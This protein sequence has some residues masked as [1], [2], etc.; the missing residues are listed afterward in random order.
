[1]NCAVAQR[2]E[3]SDSSVFLAR[4]SPQNLTT[5]SLTRRAAGCGLSGDWAVQAREF[6][7]SPIRSLRHTNVSRLFDC[8]SPRR[9]PAFVEIDSVAER[10]GGD[11]FNLLSEGGKLARNI[12]KLG[13]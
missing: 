6:A 7:G 1:M 10:D 4:P 3:V 9:F 12:L 5:R 13:R 2:L 11:C 8:R